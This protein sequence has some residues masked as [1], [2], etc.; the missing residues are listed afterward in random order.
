MQFLGGNKFP[1]IVYLDS[2]IG[3]KFPIIV[4]LDSYLC[5]VKL[6]IFQKDCVIK[7]FESIKCNIFP[8]NGINF[9]NIGYVLPL[10]AFFLKNPV[11]TAWYL[12]SLSELSN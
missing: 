3:N 6:K 5:F 4:N 7:N 11:Q 2:H 8:K 12:Q 9:H 10:I 1:I